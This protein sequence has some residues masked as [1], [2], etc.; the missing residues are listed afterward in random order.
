MRACDFKSGPSVGPFVHHSSSCDVTENEIISG[1][2]QDGVT[3]FLFSMT[4]TSGKATVDKRPY[5][6]SK[7][8][9]HL[10]LSLG[11]NA[12]TLWSNNNYAI[13][14]IFLKGKETE[15]LIS[16]IELLLHETR[17]SCYSVNA[18]DIFCV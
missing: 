7:P 15:L 12:V 9:S 5:A 18:A 13:I 8:V 17:A 16:K 14:P 11:I 1:R 10:G 4:R 6:K 3:V 2:D